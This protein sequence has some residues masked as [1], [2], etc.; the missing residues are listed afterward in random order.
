M[1]DAKNTISPEGKAQA[2]AELKQLTEVRRAEIRQSIKSAR[3][4][5]DLSENAE[6]HAAREAQG[7]NESRIRVLEHLLA[8]AVVS[9]AASGG[10]AGVG[11]QVSYRD[12]DSGKVTDVTL[13]HRLEADLAAGKLSVESPIG[14]ALLGA[15]KGDQV[16]FETPRGDS[17]QL[18]VLAVS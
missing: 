5:G 13:V 14:Q 10:A 9:E 6:Y 2:E 8:S 3:E 15:G 7:M 12:P 16:S 4:F 1:A 18:E 11:S 17:K